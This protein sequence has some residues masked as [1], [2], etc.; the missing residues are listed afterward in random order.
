MRLGILGGT[1]NPI[2]N[3]HLRLGEAAIK[4]YKLD[5]VLY[6]PTGYSYLK[7]QTDMTS[8][9]IRLDMCKLAV[10]E[11]P[12]FE[13]SDIEIRRS[14]PT[15]TYETLEELKNIYP[16]S[17][18]F[19]ITGTDTLVNI[20]TWKKPERILKLATL[21]VACRDVEAGELNRL[22]KHRKLELGG[23]IELLNMPNVKIS[24]SEIRRKASAGE[25]I[26]DMVPEAVLEYIKDNKLY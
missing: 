18:L 15:Y 10:K 20:T 14:G 12:Y 25:D 11:N 2:H 22:I 17:E 21:L 9:E 23:D 6:I 5:K 1:F 16:D 4:E 26:A 19:F 13:V 3:G 24:S 8:G 7:D